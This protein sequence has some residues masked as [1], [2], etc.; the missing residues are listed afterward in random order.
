MCATDCSVKTSHPYLGQW[1]HEELNL[2]LYCVC[3]LT[4]IGSPTISQSAGQQE[5]PDYHGESMSLWSSA[6]SSNSWEHRGD[7]QRRP[8]RPKVLP[9]EWEGT[10]VSGCCRGY[11]I[12]IGLFQLCGNFIMDPNIWTDS[13]L[14]S[15]ALLLMLF[16]PVDWTIQRFWRSV[17]ILISCHVRT[18]TG[19]ILTPFFTLVTLAQQGSLS[20]SL[21]QFGSVMG[22]KILN[23]LETHRPQV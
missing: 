16:S 7:Q 20:L 14:W 18:H 15:K 21:H 17:S 13:S 1:A 11:R 22:H 8:V 6:D 4:C 23:F 2:C 10:M 9:T 3:S 19:S 5:A 12:E